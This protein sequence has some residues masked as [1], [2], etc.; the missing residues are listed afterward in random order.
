[1]I[2]LAQTVLQKVVLH[3]TYYITSVNSYMAI[4]VG[5]GLFVPKTYLEIGDNSLCTFIKVGKE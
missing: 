4:T 5:S 1:M 3:A 2:D